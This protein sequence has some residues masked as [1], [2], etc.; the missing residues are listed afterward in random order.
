MN[1]LPSQTQKLTVLALL[2]A[3][4]LSGLPLFNV[5][6]SGSISGTVYVDYNMNGM[7][8]TTGT[9]PNYAVDAGIA[10]VTVTAYDSSGTNQ[11][12]TTSGATGTYTL[13]ATGTGPYRIE[14]TTLPS[15]FSPSATGTNNASTVRIVPD[16]ATANVDLGIIRNKDF[17]QP[18]PLMVVPVYTNGDPL[19]GGTAGTN[20]ALAGFRYSGSDTRIDTLATGLQIGATWGI[21]WQGNRNRVFSAAT[22]KRH[23]GIGPQGKGGIYVTNV[24]TTY[25]TSSFVDLTAAPYNLTL[26]ALGTNASR[27]LPAAKITPN[28]DV[29]AF[30]AVAKQGLGD[31][32]IDETGNNLWGVNINT[33][34]QS[35]FKLDVS[36]ATPGT[37]VNYPISGFTGVPTCTNGVFRPWALSFN[38][39]LG[40]LGGVCSAESAGG[41]RANLRGYVLSFDPTSPTAFTTVLD[42]PLDYNKGVVYND[43]ANPFP[44]NT[45]QWYPWTDTYT[46]AA[47]NNSTNGRLARPTPIMS[48]IEFDTNNSMSIGFLDRATSQIG[49]VNYRPIA[50]DTTFKAGFQGGDILKACQS[51]GVWSVENNGSCG[52]QTGSGVANTQG[53]GNGEFYAQDLINLGGGSGHFEISSGSLANYRGSREVISTAFD[54]LNQVSA[55]G[56]VMHNTTNGAKVRGVQLFANGSENVDGLF[57]KANGIGDVELLKGDAPLQVGNLIWNDSNGNGIQDS[58]EAGIPN[59]DVQLW[60]DTN[61]DGTVDTQVGTVQT[62]SNGNYVFGGVNNAN[63]STTGATCTSK[64]VSSVAVGSDDGLEQ[65]SLVVGNNFSNNI[66]ATTFINAYRFTNVNVP[67][68]ATITSANIFLNSRVTGATVTL[69]QRINAQDSDNPPTI[70]NVNSNISGRTLIPTLVNWNG[71]PAFTAGT[72]YSTPDVGT[73]VQSLVNRPGWVN[74]NAMFFTFRNNASVGTPSRDMSAYESGVSTAPSL[75]VNYNVPCTYTVNPN[76]AYQVRIPNSE[77]GAGQPLVGLFPTNDN[78]DA[79]ANGDSRD[80]DGSGIVGGHVAANFNTGLAGDNNHTFDFGFSPT[81]VYS[82]GNRVWYDTNSNGRIDAAEVGIGNISVSIFNDTGCDGT[83]DGAALQTLNTDANGYYRFDGLVA[84]C[85]VARVNPS[86]FSGTLNG[87]KNTTGNVST[88]TDSDVTNAGENGINPADPQNSVNTNGIL[89][90]T[91][92]LGPGAV[93]PIAETDVAASGSYAGQGSVD[94][95]ADMTVDFGFYRMSLSGTVWSDT[96]GAGNNDGI[97]NNGESGI[98]AVVVRLYDSA[99][100]E[101]P[102]GPD[103]IL[104]TA[105]DAVGGMNTNG[106][107]NYNFQGLPPGTY[108]V[109]VTSNTGTSS[110]PTDTNADNND[111]NDDNG[112]PDNTGNFPGRV[113]SGLITLTPGGEPT[114]TNSTGLTSNLTVDFGFVLAPTAIG[115]ESFEAFANADGSVTLKWSTGSEAANLGFNIYRETNGKRERLN[116]SPIAGSALRSNATLQV[117]GDSYSWFDAKSES[118]AFYYLE[119]IDLDGNTNLHDAVSAKMQ[120]SSSKSSVNSRLLSDLAE[121]ST[122]S[123]QTDSTAIVAP[124]VKGNKAVQDKLA[125]QT[126]VKIAVK[127]DGWYRVSAEQLRAAGFEMNSNQANW[128][129]FANGAQVPFRINSDNS[130]E[131][132]GLGLDML[133]T[134]KQIYYLT[135][136]DTQGQRVAEI[137]GGTAGETADAVSFRNVTVR[138]DRGLYA[139][140]I[141]NGEAENWFGAIVTSAQTT[142]DLTVHNPH[143]N[144]ATARL[145]VKLQGLTLS[146]HFVGV[147][148]NN[149]DLGTINYSNRENRAFEFEVP[150]SSVQSGTNRVSLRSIG[151]G[152]DISLVDSITLDY[153]R[154]YKAENDRLRFTVPAGQTVRVGGFTSHEFEVY[155]IR[156]GKV[157]DQM[158]VE[159]EKVDGTPGFS[160]AAASTNREFLAI[161]K[162]QAEQTASVEKD[163]SSD[164]RNP[165]NKADFVII[166]PNAFRASAEQLA[167]MR[168]AQGLN[169][170]VV[171]V[172]DLYDEFTFGAHSP[173]AVREFLRTATSQWKTKPQYALFFGDSSYDSRNYLG[174]INRDLIPTKMIDT[175]YLET[176]SDASLADF[177][178]DGI[179][180]IS[181]GRLPVVDQ[182][183][184]EAMISKLQR[185]ERQTLREERSNLFVSDTNFESYSN[186]LRD[187]L[188]EGV[189]SSFVNRTGT[190]D[191]EMRQ[192]LLE[193]LNIGATVVTYSGH[194]SSTVMTNVS[195]F[196]NEDA[197]NLNNQK[198]SFYL[199]MTCLN[200]YAHSPSTESLAESLMRSNNGAVAVWASSGT[201]TADSQLEMSQSATNLLFNSSQPLRIGAIV[202]A[203]KQS[204]SDQDSRRTWQLIGDPTIFIR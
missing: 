199:M 57:G 167:Q 184:A 39:G 33:G 29:P 174:G 168:Q 27:G 125:A 186:A 118:G 175:E 180:D 6:A 41:V 106:S 92:T 4:A 79:T 44:A 83:P 161:T 146:D 133:S 9:A 143:T 21:A 46:D 107:G 121:V 93:E 183:E 111:D 51:G 80:S 78:N 148:F 56:V 170:A 203:A 194:G 136:G 15:G 50:A 127:R 198:L 62:D 126:G 177:D 189:G 195:V 35:I 128:Q 103:G 2:F 68:N 112:F 95:Q 36:A 131:F 105:D 188:P 53:P 132:F 10:G 49:Y 65:A 74:G 204:T 72:R 8:N 116:A 185:Y 147:R 67:K 169:T 89:S 159:T 134:D 110:T 64:A 52:S 1:R 153:A 84:G 32:D 190:T 19:G 179:E 86:N 109:V 54:P 172:E 40:Y 13:S 20:M 102:V 98:P 24:G 55:Q 156:G 59:V 34:N 73:I 187:L 138:R 164:W 191:S 165:S 100:I 160:L 31:I 192:S 82:L 69:N 42:I 28:N 150:I 157:S 25:T 91:I 38:N 144:G 181:L 5:S 171:A 85:Y 137:K 96:S 196:S 14:F 149:I 108:R 124:K 176:A 166:T 197:L 90:N 22:V 81:S 140:G 182:A 61:S 117:S 201:T 113:I 63:L 200:G 18:D 87:Y 122:A 152:S 58:N 3:I 151:A 7:M 94:N 60:A 104:G 163:E 120:S 130:I 11:G 30:A 119:D 77:F 115:L 97:L 193:K 70:V 155:E 75:E 71:I 99:G 88:D 76:T 16:G 178:N 141:L 202:R 142:Q 48:D 145:T 154:L 162:L 114:V 66:L 17:T 129:M 37:F 139:S 23:V 173:E 101:I 12:S 43:V 158:A 123:V 45:T 47:F 135:V 26:G